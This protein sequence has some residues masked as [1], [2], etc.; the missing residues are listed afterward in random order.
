[1]VQFVDRDGFEPGGPCSRILEEIPGEIKEII[2]QTDRSSKEH[3]IN[4]IDH[5]SGMAA[6]EAMTGQEGSITEKQSAR[7]MMKGL[8]LASDILSNG[9]KVDPDRY[10]R[11]Q[12]HT[13]PK[14]HVGMSLADLKSFADDIKQ[15]GSVPDSTLV[16]VDTTGGEVVLAGLYIDSELSDED[17][18]QVRQGLVRANMPERANIPHRQRENGLLDAFDRAGIETCSHSIDR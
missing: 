1:M 11:H 14:G 8:T 7:T 6:T 3:I 16:A 17:V 12:I 5:K 13:H 18:E 15:G 10:K 4:V 2:D 9:G